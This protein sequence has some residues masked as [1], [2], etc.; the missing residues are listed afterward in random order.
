MV[1]ENFKVKMLANH[2]QQLLKSAFPFSPT[3]EQE[4]LIALLSTFYFSDN[5][6]SAFLLKGYAGTGKTTLISAFIKT[7]S[8]LE[9]QFVL[10]APTGRAAKVLSHLSGFSAFTIHKQIYRQQQV[11]G[12]PDSLGK[13]SFG[14][15]YNKLKDTL[16][17]VDEA[18]MITNR[19]DDFNSIFGSG[20]LL[21]ELMRYVYSGSRC[22]LVFIGDLAQLPPVGTVLSPALDPNVLSGYGI[23]VYEY[24]LREVLRQATES[25]I[26]S[27]ATAI[28]KK[29]A[30][31][32][33]GAIPK[34]R[35]NDTDVIAVSGEFLT[36]YISSSYD[37][38]GVDNTIII[39]RSNKRANIYNQGVRN[40]VLYREEEL[41]A[42]DYLMVVKN[43]YHWTK[44]IK[45]LDFVANGDMA[46]VVRINGYHD[47]YEHR[48]ADVTL[49]FADYDN[50]EL[51]TRIILSSIL[52]DSAS[53][54]AD[55]MHKLYEA[56]LED[57]GSFKTKSE[58]YK[59]MRENP[60]Y[61]ALQVKF[62]YAVTCHKSQGGQWKHVYLDLGYVTDEMVDMEFLRWLYTAVTRA[63]E[64]LYLINFPT[65]I[66]DYTKD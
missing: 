65:A 34:F 52:H 62:G 53:L 49:R 42:G 50:F 2:F 32:Q 25:G 56:I 57:F 28:R 54:S 5:V 55:E 47:L 29:L 66:L 22:R 27:T 14:L 8:Q 38:V 15:D 17:I 21:D 46:E 12:D 19:S 11:G 48:F 30:D 3:Q 7:L 36:D 63:T 33:F 4:D 37:S 59:S 31:K 41:I 60:Y 1:F 13:G 45:E 61:N 64:K 10:L 6:N 51:D 58:Q 39:T 35:V 40:T 9:Q 24:T 44:Q 20:D 18:S 23:D 16:F 43:N 26:L